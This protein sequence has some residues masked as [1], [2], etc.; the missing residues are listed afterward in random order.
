[1]KTSHLEILVEERS[2]EA[3]LQAFLPSL[4]REGQTFR[5][6]SF[7]GKTDL[8]SKLEARLKGYAKW[9]PSDWRII[10][11]VDRDDEDCL[12]LKR[13]LEDAAQRANLISRTRSGG[14][15]W[16]IANRIAIE[17]LEAWYF[18]DWS[19]VREA[20]P[21]VKENLS[22]KKNF[23]DPDAIQNTWESLEKILQKHGYFKG[24]LTKIEAAR[25][26]GTH[27]RPERNTSHSFG[28]FLRTITEISK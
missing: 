16:H 24:G 10:V 19:A 11:I 28:V 5:T 15:A 25:K 13:Q 9:L 6:V 23:R 21:R 26:I 20:Y 8:L 22:S 4:L 27:I 18:G 12:V 1:M 17:E 14:K 7:Q 3:F 2:M